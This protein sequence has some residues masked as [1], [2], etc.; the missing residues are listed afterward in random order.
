[1]SE[2]Q[3]Y[4]L[5]WPTGWK[6]TKPSERKRATFSRI[7]QTY[8]P[9]ASGNGY[10]RRDRSALSISDAAARLAGELRRLGVVEGDWLISSNVKVRLDGLPY[11]NVAPPDDPGVA[12]YFRIG[13]E[14][15]PRVLAC[16]KWD[17]VADNI[18]AV[19][20]HI[21]AIRA[22]ERYGVGNLDQAF[23]GYAA[24]PEKAD[25][26]DWRAEFGFKVDE[27][28]STAIVE[29]RFRA[30]A[31]ERHPDV[32]GGSHEAMA[33]LNRARTAAYEELAH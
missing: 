25:G 1:M 17:R 13:S 26:S 18:A 16:D 10:T 2:T 4:P 29:A 11:S 3:R 12:V 23:A 24:I 5:S 28:V 9:S 14:R 21:E 31:R 15:K 30:L 7:K 27:G 32:G 33:R 20:G 8:V 22:Q 6:R 19:A